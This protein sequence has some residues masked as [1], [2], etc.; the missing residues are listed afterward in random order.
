MEE[1][2]IQ[3]PKIGAAHTLTSNLP[4]DALGPGIAA[5]GTY[6]SNDA[7]CESLVVMMPSDADFLLPSDN[8][9]SSYESLGSFCSLNRKNILLDLAFLR[10]YPPVSH[11]INM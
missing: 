7:S 4:L 10:H 11:Y 5:E 3:T 9:Y 2:H 8:N 1:T 6:P